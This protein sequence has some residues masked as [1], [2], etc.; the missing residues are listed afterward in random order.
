MNTSSIGS[1]D[2]SQ[3]ISWYSA[4]IGAA[5]TISVFAIGYL[6]LRNYSWK[7]GYVN[8]LQKT[9][10][11]LTN[12]SQEQEEHLDKLKIQIKNLRNELDK[13]A[14]HLTDISAERDC[15]L[16][17]I[18]EYL[19]TD[20]VETNLLNQV[21]EFIESEEIESEEIESEESDLMLENS[22]KIQQK[23]MRLL[24]FYTMMHQQLK[25]VSEG[26][27]SDIEDLINQVDTLLSLIEKFTEFDDS[28][29]E[30]ALIEISNQNISYNEALKE[31][32]ELIKSFREPEKKH[33][34]EKREILNREAEIEE[35]LSYS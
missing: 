30:S 16:K 2:S 14:R 3:T 28:R 10:T 5:S 13:K 12:K 35:I 23:D 20:D 7:G 6:V 1:S 29:V 18:H 4:A 11:S 22:A 33:G 26:D 8:P 24:F 17:Q 19:D 25:L 21:S 32:S 31:L 34:K 15:Y 27:S 9:V